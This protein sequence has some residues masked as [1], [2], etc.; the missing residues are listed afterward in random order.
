MN[1]K[2][3][4]RRI[5]RI[6]V[7][8]V[9][10]VWKL[11]LLFRKCIGDLSQLANVLWVVLLGVIIASGVILLV[12]LIADKP[13]VSSLAKGMTLIDLIRTA[14]LVTGGVGGVVAL[15]V[16]YRKQ[17]LGERNEKRD[18]IA[19][20]RA[21]RAEDR[22]DQ[23]LLNE[24]FAAASEQ[25]GSEIAMNR[26]AGVY[27]MAGLADD[28][29]AGRQECIDVLCAYMRRPVKSLKLNVD[30]GMPYSE[31]QALEEER[32][33]RRAII[34]VIGRKLRE[35]EIP[36]ST[37]HGHEF[38][39][40][41]SLID[42]GDLSGINFSRTTMKFD[43]SNFVGEGIDFSKSVFTKCTF[44]FNGASFI[45]ASISFRLARFYVHIPFL[46]VQ[47]FD[48]MIDFGQCFTMKGSQIDL[49]FEEASDA[50]MKFSGAYLNGGDIYI[51]DKL[52]SD[53]TQSSIHFSFEKTEFKAGTMHIFMTGDISFE[54]YFNSVP[55]QLS[56][57]QKL[58]EAW[59]QGKEEEPPF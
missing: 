9:V 33:V 52:S 38:D 24:R 40:S 8:P 17:R 59:E 29:D 3:V 51:L 58:S 42:G 12:W 46:E 28:W 48:S 4:N 19:A 30:Q 27:A 35:D 54:H 53:D 49:S 31:K 39:L 47:V 20:E 23:K 36:G 16:A 41:E 56:L 37:W 43:K 55:T 44:S 1:A 34:N 13:D 10:A 26:F 5:A 14:L 2:K 32:Q 21:S 15:V 57:T 11:W 50:I 25:L 18:E 6:I 45:N 7:S 22:E